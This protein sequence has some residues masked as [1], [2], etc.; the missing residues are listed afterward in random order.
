[1]P[2]GEELRKPG[3]IIA[4]VI[5]AVGVIAGLLTGLYFYYQSE[6]AGQ[7]TMRVDQVQVF[8]KN[9]VD[10]LPLKIIDATG[11]LINENVFA[12][13]VAVWNSGNAEITKGA[14]RQPFRIVLEGNVV[15]LDLSVISYSSPYEGFH[16]E[17]DGSISWEHFDAGHGFKLR[18]VYV[19]S[20]LENVILSGSANEVGPVRDSQKLPQLLKLFFPHYPFNLVAVATLILAMI[21]PILIGVRRLP[22]WRF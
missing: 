20:Q 15:P 19:H 1:M 18:I 13:N 12:A 21:P 5:G 16:V 6:K 3:N 4:I 17:S 9:R 2:W 7:I 8:D 11:H 10:Q 22:D 14:V